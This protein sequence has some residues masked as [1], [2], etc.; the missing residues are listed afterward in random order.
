MLEPAGTQLVREGQEERVRTE[1]LRTEELVG[2][3]DESVPRLLG[4]RRHLEARLAIARQ[5]DAVLA[6]L[7]PD[8]NDLRVLTAQHRGID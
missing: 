4:F 8:G 5:E 3:F 6:A 1:R 7:R 2:F